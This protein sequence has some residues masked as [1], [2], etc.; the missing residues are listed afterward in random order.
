[1]S[2]LQPALALGLAI[3]CA[4]TAPPAR[5][6]GESKVKIAVL[7]LQERGVDKQLAASASSL[8]ASE[9]QKL[10]VFKVISREDIR[11]MLQFEKDK[12]SVGCEADQACLAEIG[13]ALGVEFI[14]A[15]SLAKVGDT[16]IISLQ[17][18]NVKAASVDNR[19]SETVQGKPDVLIAAVGRNA[20][21][22]VSKVL[23]GREGWLVLTVA[24]SG[25]AVKLDGQIKGSSPMKG[26]ITLSW[27]PHLLEV[28]K[29]GFVT[30]AEDISI[31]ARQ[32]LAKSV[33]LVPSDDFI[34]A[35]EG[36]AKRMR[37]GA[38]ITSGVAVV[39]LGG[40]LAFNQLSG[41]TEQ[42]LADLTGQ[43]N[44]NPSNPDALLA[45]M[46]TEADKG[47]SQVLLARIG[48]G[49]GLV[50]AAA[51]T[52]F[53]IAGEDPHRYEGYRE[54]GAE[55]PKSAQEVRTIDWMLAGAPA[56]GGGVVGLAGRF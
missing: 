30:Y 15:G 56:A 45:Q 42:R 47:N 27:G 11:N 24:E 8:V 28:E 29:A 55:A 40:A 25:A 22:L 5:A 16:F 4:L 26:R 50:A 51:A 18:N 32:V 33:A 13:G 17:L 12:Q 19:V 44:N 7:D 1:M 49:V 34:N 48:L 41:A 9:L 39:G 35:Y 46:K 3:T 21:A 23:K 43:Y 37:L 20:K 6:A 38:W 36:S 52:W 14:V 53:W 31:P 2:R 10:D 54:A